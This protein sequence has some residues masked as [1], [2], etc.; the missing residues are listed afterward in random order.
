MSHAK[1]APS[2]AD[3]WSRC[4][5]SIG[6]AEDFPDTGSRDAAYGTDCHELAAH[7]LTH[8]GEPEAR[9]GGPMPMGNVV[10]DAMVD[11]VRPCVK[12]V[13]DYTGDEGQ[14]HVEFRLDF[15]EDAGV[16]DQFGTADA[17]VVLPDEIQV[18]DHKFGYHAV[19]PSSAQMMIYGLAA[20]R[21]WDNGLVERV[22]LVIHQPRVN[23]GPAEHVVEYTEMIRFA[24]TLRSW[25][26]AALA[27]D[28]PLNPGEKQCRFCPA[29]AVCPALRDHALATIADDF[30]DIERPI[31]PQLAAIEERVKS[32]D[33]AHIANLLGAADLIE[34]WIKAVRAR[35]EEELL[36]GR[37]VPGWKL[38]QGRRGARAWADAAQAEEVL[39]SMRLKHDQMYDYKV[40]SPTSAEKLAKAGE[41]GPRQWPKL[42]ALI[43][44]SDGSPSVAPESDK[45]PAIV[46]TPVADDFDNVAAPSAQTVDDLL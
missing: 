27:P 19:D 29:K 6:Y 22:R 44:Q 13:R 9:I 14:L 37:A 43:T 2:A 20:L 7:C 1:F 35:A 17:V 32:S 25:V 5:G 10:D 45:R 18:H 42:Q 3:R 40:I 26:Q 24:G 31:A 15:S 30:V 16:A 21:R 39:K 36:A 8:G 46:V 28:A 38:V 12:A 11:L 4:P 41:I 34:S 33:N 23:R